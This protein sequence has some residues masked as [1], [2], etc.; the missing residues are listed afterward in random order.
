MPLLT[1]FEGKP[2]IVLNP[3]VKPPD[4]PFSFG[5]AKAKIIIE[6]FNFIE[7]WYI[8]PDSNALADIS[9]VINKTKK[10]YLIN[11]Y[12]AELIIKYIKDIQDF[13][14]RSEAAREIESTGKMYGSRFSKPLK[15]KYEIDK[16]SE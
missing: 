5:I 4:M 14:D 10:R 16:G 3:K 1:K 13:V 15:D 2:L 6:K 8:D 11:K 9:P 7:N 12:Q